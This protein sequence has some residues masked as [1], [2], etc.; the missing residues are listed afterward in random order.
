MH[1]VHDPSPCKSIIQGTDGTYEEKDIVND[2]TNSPNSEENVESDLHKTDDGQTDGGVQSSS[3]E[4]LTNDADKKS[5]NEGGVSD[6]EMPGVDDGGNE[7]VSAD[8]DSKEETIEGIERESKNEEKKTEA[9]VASESEQNDVKGDEGKDENFIEGAEGNVQEKGKE[10][11]EVMKCSNPEI[12]STSQTEEREENESTNSPN[13]EENVE[14]DLH[15]R[16][17]GEVI[18]A[19]SPEKASTSKIE[20]KD[21][22]EESSEKTANQQGEVMET[23]GPEIASTSKIEEKDNREETL[24]NAGIVDAE[25]MEA[26]SPQTSRTEGTDYSSPQKVKPVDDDDSVQEVASDKEVVKPKKKVIF[27]FSIL[28]SRSVDWNKYLP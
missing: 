7:T 3:E 13:S 8:S 23:S 9:E 18:E 24:Q 11:A 2:S 15:K 4:H 26:S 25:M 27:I 14:I 1:R 6:G 17:D 10:E 16:E 19:S 20:E 5:D 21:N 28:T 22:T 12:E